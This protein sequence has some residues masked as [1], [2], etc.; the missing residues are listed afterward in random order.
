MR[1][2]NA[3]FLNLQNIEDAEQREALWRQSMATLAAAVSSSQRSMPLEGLPAEP[4][5]ESIHVALKDG[6]FDRLDW[7]SPTAA[8]AAMYEI[9]A[10]LPASAE[11]RELGKK[12]LEKLRRGEASTFVA[13]A[14]RL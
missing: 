1:A 9:A 5:S 7:I 2:H 4:F 11:K 3:G 6:F 13:L 12:V 14:I 8:A 10:A